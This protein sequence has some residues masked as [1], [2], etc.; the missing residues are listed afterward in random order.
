MRMVGFLED[1]TERVRTD[2]ALRS[3]EERLAKAFRSSPDAISIARQE[4]DRL[5]EVNDTWEAMFG[6]GRDKAVGRTLVELGLWGTADRERFLRLLDT[7]HRVRDF[8][9]D[10]RTRTG[11]HSLCG[12][13]R[14]HPRNGRGAV[15]HH[16][17]SRHHRAETGRG[18][19]AGAAAGSGP[20]ESRG[21]AGCTLRRAGARAE[22]APDRHPRQCPRGPAAAARLLARSE[23]SCGTFSRTSRRT[24]AGRARSSS[25]SGRSSGR[26]TCSPGTWI[27]TRS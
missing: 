19:S 22:P 20:P 17:H 7:E 2:Q 11:E 9:V 6:Y 13:R 23:S 15:L 4:D 16:L 18:R 27:S 3:S 8:E 14:R 25:G 24:I 26:G 12:C 21:G 10:L 1:V 5:L